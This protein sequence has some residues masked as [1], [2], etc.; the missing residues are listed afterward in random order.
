MDSDASPELSKEEILQ[1]NEIKRQ[2]DIRD[3]GE[4]LSELQ[5]L[6]HSQQSGVKEMSSRVRSLRRLAINICEPRWETDKQERTDWVS[7]NFS[8]IDTLLTDVLQV[9]KPFDGRILKHYQPAHSF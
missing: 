7:A 8:L 9:A 5:G 2:G 4:F 6:A 3:F 1:N